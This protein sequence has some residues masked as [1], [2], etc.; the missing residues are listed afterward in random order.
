MNEK[1]INDIKNIIKSSDKIVFFGGAGVSTASGLKDF[2]GKDGLYLLKSKYNKSYEEMLSINY[3]EEY[4]E[5]FYKFYKEFFLQKNDIEPNK[6]HYV[7]AEFEKKHNLKIITQNVDGLHQKAESKN[8][9]ELHGSI[10]KN[11]CVKCHKNY[12]I[13][14]VKQSIGV[15][16]C[17][18]GGIIRPGIVFYGEM[19]DV[20]NEINAEKAVNEAD[21]LIVGGTSLKVYPAAGFVRLFHGKCLIIINNDYTDYDYFANYV[22]HEDIGNVLEKILL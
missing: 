10:E 22:F 5:T 1:Q 20:N 9:I 8:V 16:Y 18:C 11:Y 15:P 6:A 12:S 2:R 19:L 17:T 21:V 3:F 4:P 13:D 7:L 14:Y